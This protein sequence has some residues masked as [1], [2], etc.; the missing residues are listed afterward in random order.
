MRIWKYLRNK[1]QALWK[2]T[3]FL[4]HHDIILW[5]TG[6]PDDI[7]VGGNT[8]KPCVVWV[9]GLCS[10]EQS[11][12]HLDEWQWWQAPA[13][14]VLETA[15]KFMGQSFQL[16]SH[17][18]KHLPNVDLIKHSPWVEARITLK[19][20]YPWDKDEG[21]L[22]LF[23]VPHEMDALNS[24]YFDKTQKRKVH[25]KLLLLYLHHRKKRLLYVLPYHNSLI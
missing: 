5:Q 6:C 24:V 8:A 15:C 2:L 12:M 7:C 16:R 18:G 17:H 3:S 25:L 20:G 9:N 13:D 11:C 4:G 23:F 1:S 19:R 10:S 22:N 21:E 14:V